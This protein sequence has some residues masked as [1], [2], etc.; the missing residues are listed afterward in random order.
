MILPS[1]PSTLTVNSSPPPVCGGASAVQH[2]FDVSSGGGA[3]P[4]PPFDAQQTLTSSSHSQR[5]GRAVGK[6][7]LTNR[8]DAAPQVEA[9]YH[10]YLQ[11][12][13]LRHV[14]R[15]LLTCGL[16][17]V[18]LGGWSWLWEM[19]GALGVGRSIGTRWG[20]ASPLFKAA[21]ILLAMCLV[22]KVPQ[23]S[24]EELEDLYLLY[25]FS[26]EKLLNLKKSQDYV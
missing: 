9:D 24:V 18:V 17:L 2:T 1:G 16:L 12:H 11:R 10:R 5:L 26:L 3:A 8:F 19:L 20:P 25:Q 23:F 21:M 15:R 4:P 7:W 6:S 14:K 22:L 13:Q